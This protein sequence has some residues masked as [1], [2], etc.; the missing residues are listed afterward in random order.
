MLRQILHDFKLGVTLDSTGDGQISHEAYWALVDGDG[1]YRGLYKPT[2][3][4]IGDQEFEKM[5]NDIENVLTEKP[6]QQLH[7]Q[8]H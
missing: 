6:T 8:P 3:P 1:K 7:A 5:V 4:D 2:D